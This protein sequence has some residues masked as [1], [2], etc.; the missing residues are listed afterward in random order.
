[1][2]IAYDPSRIA[3]SELPISLR[4]RCKSD[5]LWYA[6]NARA[7]CDLLLRD[8]DPDR[9]GF[10]QDE[11]DSIAAVAAGGMWPVPDHPYTEDDWHRDRTFSAVPG[12]EVE[13]RIYDRMLDVMPP[14]RLPRCKRT[15]GFEKGFMVGEP[16][17]TD[18]V[19]GRPS[20]SAFGKCG[21]RCYYIG[22][23]PARPAE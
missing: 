3:H 22:L 15:E 17:D 4:A 7:F 9:F 5:E 12:Q 16:A 11:W 21:G 20:Y 6:K 18:P 14:I 8:C 23:L 1:M 2:M 13:A 10:T 19:T